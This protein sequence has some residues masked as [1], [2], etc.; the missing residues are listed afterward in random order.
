MQRFAKS[1]GAMD[2]NI[3]VR[4]DDVRKKYRRLTALD[5]VSLG[6]GQ[7]ITAVLGR[8]GAG[9]STLARLIVGVE[10]PTAGQVRVMTN[11]RVLSDRQDRRQIGWLPQSFGF[12]AQMNVV[13]FVRYAAWLKGVDRT[14]LPDRTDA[15]LALS[16]LEDVKY[17]KLG[18][19]SGGTMRRAGLAASLA[20]DPRVLILDEPTAG[21]D[22]IQRA[23]FHRRLRRLASNR[24]ILLATHLLEDVHELADNIYVLD[25]GRVL[26]HGTAAALAELG[27]G[28]SD[29]TTALRAGM[30]R[31]IE[32]SL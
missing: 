17:Q 18:Q 21:L 15:A 6:F 26:W 11:D 32:E 20:H 1:K 9:K 19:L 4:V 29:G 2:A 24:T 5:G 30:V 13:E 3:D 27:G 23:D 14:A 12:P 28:S 7:G 10:R 8:N 16:D 31:L 25:A 22:P